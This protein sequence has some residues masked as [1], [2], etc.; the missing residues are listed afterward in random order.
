MPGISADSLPFSTL[1]GLGKVEEYPFAKLN[2]KDSP[3]TIEVSTFSTGTKTQINKEQL[4]KGR[5]E[6]AKLL[7]NYP[8]K[9]LLDENLF[10]HIHS[11]SFIGNVKELEGNAMI[12]TLRHLLGYLNHYHASDAKFQTIK[13]ELNQCLQLTES[14][15]KFLTID[16]NNATQDYKKIVQQRISNQAEELADR[17]RNGS[18]PVI[19]GGG[20]TTKNGGH[21]MLYR[22]EGDSFTVFNTGAGS[23]YHANLAADGK[24]KHSP[25]LTYKN[26]SKNPE[27]LKL[28]L[29]TLLECKYPTEYPSEE[30]D[31]NYL[32]EKVFPTCGGVPVSDPNADIDF[33]SGQIAGTCSEKVLHAFL[34]HYL[35]FDNSEKKSIPKDYKR[36][37]LNFKRNTSIAFYRNKEAL[38]GQNETIRLLLQ[39]S[40]TSYSDWLLKLNE[41][42][43]LNDIELTDEYAIL[44][45]LTEAISN[46]CD[47]EKVK[48][49][50]AAKER[51]LKEQ[52]VD[53]RLFNKMQ[54][55]D[56]IASFFPTPLNFDGFTAYYMTEDDVFFTYPFRQEP[57]DV[58]QLKK[59]L[60]SSLDF[61][62]VLEKELQKK[63]TVLISEKKI[64]LLQKQMHFDLL[65]KT[66]PV[67]C[68]IQDKD[69][70]NLWDQL[71]STDAEEIL[72]M[73]QKI[74]NGAFEATADL[75]ITN[76]KA[77]P[78]QLTSLI[79][80]YKLVAVMHKLEALDPKSHLKDYGVA[81]HELNLL[82]KS[83]WAVIPSPHEQD[84]WQQTMDYLKKPSESSQKCIDFMLRFDG[85]KKFEDEDV[86]K[87]DD[88]SFFNRLIKNS[89][90]EK[91]AEAYIDVDEAHVPKSFAI[92]R[93]QLIQAVGLARNGHQSVSWGGP[94]LPHLR[95]PTYKSP[96][97]KYSPY[98]DSKKSSNNSYGPDSGS[99]PGL[100]P[101]HYANGYTAFYPIFKHTKY[102]HE[103]SEDSKEKVKKHNDSLEHRLLSSL[104]DTR[105]TK[106][107]ND[108]AYNEVLDNDKIPAHLHRQLLTAFAD[109]KR[110]IRNRGLF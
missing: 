22:F 23:Q 69:R 84:E 37:Q 59:Q 14:I 99:F 34:R 31:E 33:I 51:L 65:M 30:Y 50:E 107:Y 97:G 54:G 110:S 40:L 6:L 26:I 70:P 53:L 16:P 19:F 39:K 83:N 47:E 10:A 55:R 52:A 79:S 2:Q 4:Q 28:F 21:A 7:A 100:N 45:A 68:A 73:F 46:K 66:L 35:P 67:P 42:G 103:D 24:V 56:T 71:K 3:D 94:M 86:L 108:I 1:F 64:L 96:D 60:Q 72:Q 74:A 93:R 78:L 101:N 76:K 77:H 102:D 106:E 80:H 13:T 62:E 85:E 91:I 104:E 90:A 87:E 95:V 38:L 92:F 17:I 98:I 11:D 12:I 43:I 105:T 18:A 48:I 41:E 61:F 57:Q 27:K 5:T 63:Q 49:A 25:V 81:T 75:Q 20:Y 44:A 109:K 58:S 89:S 8:S 15:E 32:Y 36:F 82:F 88:L 9:G 29:R